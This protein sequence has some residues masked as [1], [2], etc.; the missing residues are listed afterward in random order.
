[1]LLKLVIMVV[2][3]GGLRPLPKT[4]QNVYRMMVHV[5]V[6]AVGKGFPHPVT[7]PF[8]FIDST[9][10]LHT[11]TKRAL[12]SAFTNVSTAV[13]PRFVS[14]ACVLMLSCKSLPPKLTLI[15]SKASSNVSTISRPG[16]RCKNVVGFISFFLMELRLLVESRLLVGSG[17]W[18]VGGVEAAVGGG[19]M[20]AMGSGTGMEDGCK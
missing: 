18:R 5:P 6:N 1:M 11:D 10:S 8:R 19:L 13:S 17:A 15:A 2:D 12:A 7:K 20:A 14:F 3:F 4:P 16:T 9:M